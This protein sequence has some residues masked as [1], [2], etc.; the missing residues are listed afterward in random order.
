MLIKM[1]LLGYLFGIPSERCL[2]QE[3]QGNVA[4]RW[5]LRLGLTEKV[6]DAS[7]L[8]Q[9]RRRRFNHSEAFQQIFDN[10]VEQAIAR[11]LVGDGYSILTALT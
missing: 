3:I 11:G 8:S 10:I 9:N 5:F 6:P 7:T 4:Y 2:V 1:M